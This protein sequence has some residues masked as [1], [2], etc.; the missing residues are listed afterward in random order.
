M[1]KIHVYFI[2]K[3]NLGANPVLTPRIPEFTGGKENETDERICV[4]PTVFQCLQGLEIAQDL[5]KDDKPYEVFLY[6]ADVPVKNIIQPSDEDVPDAW[7]TGEMWVIKPQQFSI[8]SNCIIRKHMDLPNNC[9]SRYS[10]RYANKDEVIDRITG[11]PIYG[12][13]Y[14]FSFIDFNINRI[15]EALD[16]IEENS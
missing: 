4:A 15:K 3:E 8:V 10:F 11:T 12:E 13:S 6:E 7:K 9:Y 14:S 2:A 5:V 16:H 1:N